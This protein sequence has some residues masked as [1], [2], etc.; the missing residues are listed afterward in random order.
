M[1]TV[2]MLNFGEAAVGGTQKE[3]TKRL[4]ILVVK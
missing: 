4:V 1:G 3:R 2:L